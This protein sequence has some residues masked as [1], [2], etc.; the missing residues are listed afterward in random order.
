[1]SKMKPIVCKTYLLLICTLC[2]G[3]LTLR[4]QQN[5]QLLK[6]K[7]C[8]FKGSW[9]LVQTFSVGGLHQVNKS[10][11]D[12]IMC[13]RSLH[14]YY[15]EVNYESN[16]WII[17]GKWRI[18]RKKKTL[19]LT[20]RNY[21]V[22]QLEEHPKDITLSIFQSDKKN[23]AGGTTDKGQDVKVYYTHIANNCK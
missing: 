13:F 19:E 20:S 15:E 23:W 21:T 11:Y 17:E 16:H 18:N 5:Q 6:A 4:A 9:Q 10:D 14:R 8:F 2:L 3:V 12:G 7:P 1:M 22:G